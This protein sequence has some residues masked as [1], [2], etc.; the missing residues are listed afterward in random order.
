MDFRTYLLHEVPRIKKGAEPGL[1]VKTVRNIIDG[2]FRAMVRDARDID[3][4]IAG[5]PFAALKWPEKETQKRDAFT[6]EERA[7]ILDYFRSNQPFYYPFIFTMFWTGMRPANASPCAL[8]TSISRKERSRLPSRETWG[9]NG[10][11]KPS[12]SERTIKLLPNVV[13]VLRR[14]KELRVTEKDY[15]F[16]NRKRAPIDADQWRKDYWYAALRAKGITRAGFLLHPAHVH[17]PGA[18]SRREHQGDRRAVRHVGADDRATLWP[19]HE[20]RFR[21]AMMAEID[22]EPKKLKWKVKFLRAVLQ[23]PKMTKEFGVP[24]G[25]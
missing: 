17:Q 1:S 21:R 11:R 25:I 22:Q 19:L 14:A 12:D 6:K 16:K 20:Q 3:G 5:D 15:F 7:K 13:E 8:A 4:L 23:L 10:R 2:S 24:D 9:K 18:D